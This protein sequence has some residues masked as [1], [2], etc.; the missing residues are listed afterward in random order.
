MQQA[1]STHWMHALSGTATPGFMSD[2]ALL[3]RGRD[4]AQTG[5][6]L[7]GGTPKVVNGTH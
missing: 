5:D 7:S 6:F 4:L 1:P 3:G 2:G